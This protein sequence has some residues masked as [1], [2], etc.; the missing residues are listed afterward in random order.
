MLKS[1]VNLLEN[2]FYLTVLKWFFVYLGYPFFA[3][4]CF[5]PAGEVRSQEHK[6]RLF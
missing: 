3:E 4:V 6:L 5:E 2:R 1:I